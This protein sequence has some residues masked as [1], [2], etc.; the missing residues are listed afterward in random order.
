MAIEQHQSP[1]PRPGHAQGDIAHDRRER[2]GRKRQR[3]GKWP[4]LVALAVA[5]RWDDPD[6]SRRIETL[7]RQTQNALADQ[8]IGDHRQVR[9]VLLD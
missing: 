3:P 1:K 8:R 6:L 4:V 5:Q 9:T 7:E 2:L